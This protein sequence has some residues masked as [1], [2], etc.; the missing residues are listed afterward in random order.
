MKR[1]PRGGH[2]INYSLYLSVQDRERIKK[3]ADELGMA[4]AYYL[5][6]LADLDIQLGLLEH[7]ESGGLI[8]LVRG[9]DVPEPE[10]EVQ[11][12]AGAIQPGQ[13]PV[14]EDA[15]EITQQFH[16]NLANRQ[17]KLG[18]PPES[19]RE[20]VD[21]TIQETQEV[22]E[23]TGQEPPVQQVQHPIP[24]MKS[25]QDIMQQ[26]GGAFAM[27]NIGGAAGNI[28]NPGPSVGEQTGN[29]VLQP[30]WQD[31]LHG[32]LKKNDRGEATMR[33][34]ILENLPPPA[35]KGDT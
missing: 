2:K 11:E 18:F 10:V 27:P 25:I 34:Q 29:Q 33:K 14:P 12:E 8:E 35:K 21:E 26:Q 4:D 5:V 6:T 24:Q 32:E 28:R 1:L 7:I 22:L 30:G 9:E 20:E 23:Q 31:R 19:M 13:M 3:R 16:E 15:A 17:E